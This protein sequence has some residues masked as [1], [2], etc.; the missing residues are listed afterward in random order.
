VARPGKG[1][2]FLFDGSKRFIPESNKFDPDSCTRQA[3]TY[4]T[5]SLDF[6]I[7][8]RQAKS[9]I[10]DRSFPKMCRSIHEHPMKAEVGRADWNFAE[11]ASVAQMEFGE[12]LNSNVPARWCE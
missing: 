3:I 12:M 5:L 11:P 9:K 4:F 10:Y 6:N 7:R 1:F 2:Y 8:P